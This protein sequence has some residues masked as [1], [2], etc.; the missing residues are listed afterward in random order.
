[1]GHTL[2]LVDLLSIPNKKDFS[3]VLSPGGW[4]H[5]HLEALVG[6]AAEIL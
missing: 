5:V 2:E 3:L 1:M 4:W 6:A